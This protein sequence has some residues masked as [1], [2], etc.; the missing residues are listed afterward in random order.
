MDL[1]MGFLRCAEI[2]GEC[3]ILGVW[4]SKSFF[5]LLLWSK[6]TQIWYQ[7]VGFGE[8]YPNKYRFD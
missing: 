3:Q 1:L 6:T 5:M 4:D 2:F 8:L 7:N